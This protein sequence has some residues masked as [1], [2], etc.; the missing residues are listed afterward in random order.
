MPFLPFTTT[1]A[2]L[3]FQYTRARAQDNL[4]G[5]FTIYGLPPGP[6]GTIKFDVTFDIDANGVF[7]EGD[8]HG[9]DE[10]HHYH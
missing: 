7:S 4:L 5:E 3:N 10:Q 2:Q 9:A 6:K 8:D 1:S